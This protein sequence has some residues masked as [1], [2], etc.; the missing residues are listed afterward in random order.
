M[1]KLLITFMAM[2]MMISVAG[3]STQT[4]TQE[5]KAFDITINELVD[6][7]DAECMIDLTPVTVI[8]DKDGSKIATYTFSTE[9]DSID[10]SMHYQIDYDDTTKKVSYINFFF[11]KNFMGDVTNA[12]TRYLYHISAIAEILSPDIN[13]DALYDEINTVNGTNENSS[14]ISENDTFTLFAYCSEEYF[15]ASFRPIEKK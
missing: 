11:S 13:I 1:K 9:N 12:H 5:Q 15:N 6:R 7:L 10:T 2:V 14:E 3:C 4:P 8:E